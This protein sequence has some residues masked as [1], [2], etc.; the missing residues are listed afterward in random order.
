MT[1][2]K[3]LGLALILT[4]QA[5]GCSTPAS[6]PKVAAASESAIATCEALFQREAACTDSFIPMLV[7]TRIKLDLP[8]GIAATSREVLI[9]KAKEEWKVDSLPEAAARTCQKAAPGQPAAMVAS[10]RACLAESTCD[11][12]VACVQPLHEQMLAARR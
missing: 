8:A 11:A 6:E 4:A 1:R 12:F 9:A 7:D 2:I 5:L 10:A 3:K